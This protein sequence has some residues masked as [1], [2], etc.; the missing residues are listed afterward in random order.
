MQKM[1]SNVPSRAYGE[2]ISEVWEDD[3]ELVVRNYHHEGD[4]VAMLDEID[5]VRQQAEQNGMDDN[6]MAYIPNVLYFKWRKEW[7]A[8]PCQDHSWEWYRDV[9]KLNSSEYK[10]LRMFSEVPTITKKHDASPWL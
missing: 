3:E 4:L 10:R 6:V 7:E 2:P 8:G 1:Y 9:V 5:G